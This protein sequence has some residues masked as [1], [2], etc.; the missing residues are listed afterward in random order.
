MESPP[1]SSPTPN[2]LA[3]TATGWR[4]RGTGALRR[5]ARLD[6]STILIGF[7][8]A[9]GV[10][11]GIA[12]I[13]FYRLIDFIQA[14]ALS[15]A[16]SLGG[17][18][19]LSILLVVLMG[20]FAA[21]ALV[22]WGAHDSDGENIPDVMRTIAKRGGILQG[23]PVLA[24]TAA[25]GILIGTGG[26]VGA[27]GPVAVA[28]AA[29]GSKL[30]QFFRSGG[31]RL[32][33]LIGCG[34]A[35]GISAAFNAPIAGVF[36][37]L[38]KILG[39]FGVASF[40]PVLV[41]SVIAAAISRGVLGNSP[42]I[43][44]PTEYALGAPVEL[45]FYAGLG[46]ATG[47]MGVVYT[48][49]VHQTGALLGSFG[50]RWRQIAA[51]AVVV[52]ALNIAFRADLWGQGH[53]SF[54]LGIIGEREAWLLVALAFAKILATSWSLA[55]VR[56]GGV[57][58]P[59]LFIGA[60]LGGG[61]G[62]AAAEIFPELGIAPE[63]F[64]LAG[65]AG[66]V[67]GSTHAPL[68]ALMIVFEM[69]GDYALILP[70]MLT[71][72]IA[73]IFARKLHPY[74]IYSEW[75]VR[76]GEQIEFGR[77]TTV[78]ESLRVGDAYVGDPV[79]LADH[80][81]FARVLDQVGRTTQTEFPVTTDDGRLLGMITYGDLRTV[82]PRAAAVSAVLVAADIAHDDVSAVTP[83]DTLGTALRHLG[84]HGARYLPVVSDLESR[85]LL[86]LISRQEVLAAYDR[87]LLT[88]V[89]TP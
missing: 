58:T 63:A 35:A 54:S 79:V 72:A 52:G 13:L 85:R 21:W 55:A 87:A 24:K 59:A 16:D 42:V 64:A 80:Q 89:D 57:F 49:S 65:M 76:R 75:L 48:R 15:T 69:S 25:A 56:A 47:V 9:I 22:R 88:R 62:V 8:V 5:L 30:G 43:E 26:S 70:I 53:E 40:P 39:T 84:V 33:V 34:A 27:E 6:E 82:I 1:P 38:E 60:T 81:S 28:G 68:T 61:L 29:L 46:I 2:G 74:S 44:I 86:G 77:D 66:L 50:A 10:A 31:P 67:A 37:A 78:L 3:A 23:G 17:V 36:F 4:R 11:V 41:S 20:M 32:T 18:G 51:A 7:A 71:A 14:I 12:V 19:R 73:Y 45:V 83:D